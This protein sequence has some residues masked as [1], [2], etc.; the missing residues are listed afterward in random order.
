MP[1]D[2]R[3]L[4]A[5]IV[6]DPADDTARLVYADCLQEHGNIPRAEFI[7]L[8]VEAE[9]LHPDSNA[10]VRLEEKA[11]ALFAEH[12]IEW[13]G[14]ICVLTGLPMPVPKPR[15]ALGRLMRRI[16]NPVGHPYE[17]SRFEI[18]PRL[19]WPYDGR[20]AGWTLTRFRRG[21]PD[22]SHMSLRFA[23]TSDPNLLQLWQA[24]S[25]LEDAHIDVPYTDV[26][27]DGPHMS[28]LRSLTLE[29]YDPA[30]LNGVL[31]SPH[32]VRL[33][34][35]ALRPSGTLN[36]FDAMFTN[37]FARAV[38]SPRMSQ[39][40]R[41]SIPLWSDQAAE[42]V[43]GASNL[44]GLDALEVELQV[45]DPEFL[46]VDADPEGPGRR[47]AMLARSPYLSG[48][49]ELTLKGQLHTE[50]IVIA[51][52]NPTWTGLRKLE[53][54]GWLWPE[55]PDSLNECDDVP[56][57]EELRLTGISY[58]VAQVA[59]FARSPL[60]KR[61]RHFAVRGGP[62]R[63]VDFDIADAVDPD[64]IET[65]AIGEMELQTGVDTKLQSRFGDRFRVLA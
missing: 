17:V 42:V 57:L 26:W 25:P 60:L 13:W 30:A 61:L 27:V 20:F 50:G 53:L 23:S 33:E 48:L 22:C 8:Q 32:M 21:F 19:L 49:R 16:R 3:A 46:S 65:F 56:E 14:E 47:L 29:D 24:I 63:S 58:T 4:L 43:A 1:D 40:K 64:R 2:L 5:S 36:D 55:H 9:R 39:L 44:A 31:S 52:R 51:I 10:R 38:V 7:R 62:S 12:W 54:E 6:A 18:R 35:L 34:N 11:Q 45:S 41:L 37:E 28:R 15:G 59:A